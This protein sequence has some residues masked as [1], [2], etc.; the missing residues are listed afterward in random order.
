MTSKNPVFRR[1]A[2]NECFVFITPPDVAETVTAGRFTW[3]KNRAGVYIGTFVYG[4]RYLARDDAV[5]IDPVEIKLSDRTYETTLQ[6]GVFGALRDAGPDHWGRMIIDRHL[7]RKESTEFEYLIHS[8]DDRAG[9]LD[10]G[11]NN[12]PPVP[13]RK[14]SK[15]F[16]LRKLQKIADRLIK[17]KQPVGDLDEKQVQGILEINTAMGGAR[18]KAVVEDRGALWIAKFNRPN[19]DKWNNAKIE[20]TMLKLAQD[21]GITVSDSKVVKVG[22]RDVLLVKRFDREQVQPGIY[23]KCRMISGLT[24]LKVDETDQKSWSY[25]A[26]A[27]ELRRVCAD[28][29]ENAVELFRRMCF[30][31][32]VSNIDDHPRNHA[33]I[34]KGREWKLSPAYDITPSS[35]V[36]IDSRDLSMVCGDL[37]RLANEQNLLSQHGRFL[38]ER[39]EAENIVS[40]MKATVEST[41][42]AVAKRQGV[43]EADCEAIRG[44]FVYPGFSYVLEPT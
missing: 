9:A 43:S 40:D 17:D 27:E 34:A 39:P 7:K 32:L 42:Y 28:P 2:P 15:R 13:E 24:L 3:T 35:P 29:K 44:A 18:P 12:E 37:G 8:A 22:N 14:F 26:L 4:R 30:N 10:F 23:L 21:C 19:K 1:A 16:E 31:A 6:K 5:E 41:W 38:L 33:A 25:V 20:R 11:M 36:G